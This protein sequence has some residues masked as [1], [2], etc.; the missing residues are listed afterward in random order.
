MRLSL[1]HRSARSAIGKVRVRA[2]RGAAALRSR[3]STAPCRFASTE[4]DCRDGYETQIPYP[5]PLPRLHGLVTST[6][7]VRV[8]EIREAMTTSIWKDL[9]IHALRSAIE[10]RARLAPKTRVDFNCAGDDPESVEGYIRETH[11]EGDEIYR[12]IIYRAERRP[13]ET[14]SVTQGSRDI[15]AFLNRRIR[16]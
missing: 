2:L 10:S 9:M 4:A 12:L 8:R 13:I 16:N 11:A 1:A 14:V 3:N 15:P 5:L 7:N 6:R